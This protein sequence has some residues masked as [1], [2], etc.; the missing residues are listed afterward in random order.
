MDDLWVDE[1]MSSRLKLFILIWVPISCSVS[2][3]FFDSTSREEKMLKVCSKR[4]LEVHIIFR[5][6]LTV[7]FI[8]RLAIFMKERG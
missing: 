4:I 5:N 3:I 7:K 8:A 2:D 6:V 1:L